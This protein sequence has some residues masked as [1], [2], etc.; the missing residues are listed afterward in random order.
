MSGL[1]VRSASECASNVEA[2][3]IP[4]AHCSPRATLSRGCRV[5]RF[6]RALKNPQAVIMICGPTLQRKRHSH[7]CFVTTTPNEPIISHPELQSGARDG[8]P[9]E[10]LES[11]ITASFKCSGISALSE[12]KKEENYREC[13]LQLSCGHARHP[14]SSCIVSVV[15]VLFVKLTF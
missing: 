9:F 12:K 5:L 1:R 7:S 8:W 6:Q 3:D 10:I 14:L 2:V 11:Q 13:V 4:H 15:L